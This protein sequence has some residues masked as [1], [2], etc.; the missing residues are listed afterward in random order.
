MLTVFAAIALAAG[1]ATPPPPCST[2]G[3][4]I[5]LD[6]QGGAFNGMSHSGTRLAVR[7][8][9]SAPCRLPQFSP[10]VFR[11]AKGDMLP[12]ASTDTRQGRQGLIREPGALLGALTLTLLPGRSAS[13]TLRWVSGDVYDHGRCIR[14]RTIELRLRPGDRAHVRFEGTLCGEKQKP[15]LVDQSPFE[16]APP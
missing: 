2:A 10:V 6:D 12:I 13:S 1:I 5:S 7:N 15:L 14:P 11:D 9:G 8:N 16:L 4:A 3:L